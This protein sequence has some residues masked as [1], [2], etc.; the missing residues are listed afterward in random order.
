MDS[1][2]KLT[3][4]TVVKNDLVGIRRT[5][6]TLINQTYSDFEWLVID[7]HSTDGTRGFLN[8]I[9]SK[10]GNLHIVDQNPKGIYC[11]MN[12]GISRARG[13]W[14]W[15]INSGDFLINSVAI[16]EVVNDL[17]TSLLNTSVFAYPVV[18]ISRRGF[19]N[20][21]SSPNTFYSNRYLIAD[22]NHQGVIAKKDALVEIG[23]FDEFMRFASDG[24]CLDL[25]VQRYRYEIKSTSHVAFPMGGT[26]AKNFRSTLKETTTFRPRLSKSLGTNWLICKNYM[27]LLLLTLESWKF[28]SR[29][30][31]PYLKAKQNREIEE[32]MGH[33]IKS[34]WSHPQVGRGYFECCLSPTQWL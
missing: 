21:F 30:L 3:I 11:A 31:A 24:K 22:F 17:K 10:F 14:I 34:H 29:I 20:S 2:V 16:E 8:T 25:L 33:S 28:T 1:D 6:N 15:F 12:L 7:G 23:G 18:Q 4:V 26:A 9:S 5:A 27:R 19:I 13:S 32:R